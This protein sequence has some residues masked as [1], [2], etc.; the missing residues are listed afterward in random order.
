MI[1][2]LKHTLLKNSCTIYMCN[3]TETEQTPYNTA[4]KTYE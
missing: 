3:G 2:G 1:N 4:W